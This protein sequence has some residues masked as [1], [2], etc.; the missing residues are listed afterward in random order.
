MTI[1][2]V[3]FMFLVIMGYTYYARGEKQ[4]PEVEYHV[5]I[6]VSAQPRVTRQLGFDVPAAYSFH[7]GHTWVTD[8]GRQNARVGIDNFAANL[9]GKIDNVEVVGLNRWVRQGGKLMTI[10]SGDV[11]VNLVSP[12]EGVVIAVNP[13]LTRDANLAATSPYNEGW[14]AVVKSPDLTTNVKNLVNGGMVAPWMANSVTRVSEMTGQMGH[15]ADG[16]L[17]VPG[18]LAQLDPKVREEVIKDTFLL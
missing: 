16:G 14:V 15:A 5:P 3:L 17:P 1:L 8:E 10:T 18:L 13:E 6:H 4:Q 2:F 12:V 7:P 9:I 11:K